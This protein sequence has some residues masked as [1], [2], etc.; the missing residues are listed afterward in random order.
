MRVWSKELPARRAAVF[1]IVAFERFSRA[2]AL[3]LD[4]LG[5]SPEIQCLLAYERR[6]LAAATIPAFVPDQ[7]RS[8]LRSAIA[9]A[10]VDAFRLLML[11]AA[12]LAVASAVFVWLLI[13]GVKTRVPAAKRQDRGAEA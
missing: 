4:A 12:C 7:L 11:L 6:K 10:F 13:G 9:A 5:V 8:T 2:L 1:G 3:R